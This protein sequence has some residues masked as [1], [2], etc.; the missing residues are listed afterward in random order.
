M[1]NTES[2]SVSTTEIPK[3]AIFAE[4][5][6]TLEKAKILAA[7]SL[8]KAKE[9]LSDDKNDET[10]LNAIKEIENEL[11]ELKELKLNKNEEVEVIPAN[12]V[13]VNLVTK[14]RNAVVKSLDMISCIKMWIQLKIPKIE[15]GNNF[16]VG[17]QEECVDECN[18]A[19]DMSFSMLE[20]TS[21]IFPARGELITKVI[22]HPQI[23]DYYQSVIEYDQ[24]EYTNLKLG[25]VDLRYI[26]II[27]I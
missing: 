21:K 3:S 2:E 25:L 15:D 6:M 17:I 20:H 4:S 11:D 13:L 10:K 23:R 9:S 7:K 14:I 12:S 26:F 19:E 24:M 5:E 18:K 27:I 16:G 22:K 1:Y 8:L